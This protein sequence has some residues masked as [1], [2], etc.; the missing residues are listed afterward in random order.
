MPAGDVRG[1]GVLGVFD[2]LLDELLVGILG[3]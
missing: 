1:K 3:G 2:V